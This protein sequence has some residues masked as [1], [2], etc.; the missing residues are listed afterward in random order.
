[1]NRSKFETMT[2]QDL[3][4]S[5]EKWA[6]LER[7]TTTTVIEHVAEAI[8][9]KS[10]VDW[11]YTSIYEYLTRGLQLSE[12]SA[13]RRV[14][15][16]HALIQIPEIKTQIETGALN[17][18]QLV[19]VQ[20]A[21]RNEQ[22]VN[23]PVSVETKREVLT[24]LLNKTGIETQKIIDAK[25]EPQRTYQLEKHKQDDSV[26]LTVRLPK[27]VYAK[28]Q[29]IKE[30]LSHSIVDGNW[31]DI[32]SHLADEE[33]KRRDP[34]RKARTLRQD[35]ISPSASVLPAQPSNSSQTRKSL[36]QTVRRFI[37]QRDHFCQYKNPDGSRCGNR[38]Q[39][40]VDHI[41]PKFAGGLDSVENLRLLCRV[42]NQARYRLG[43]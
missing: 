22:K 26:E 10:F 39:L 17:L 3:R 19:A 30:L 41:H 32:L 29:R 5:L 33:L 28:F 12:R 37:F 24:E 27:D 25:F 43:Q 21:V 7:R 6:N 16:A 36:R 15:A 2:N 11:G 18:S 35:R 1:M 40:E 9:R 8:N 23:G 34:M 20:T 42:H 4:E 14:Q 38:Y 31:S 13:Y